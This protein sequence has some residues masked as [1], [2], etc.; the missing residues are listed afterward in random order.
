MPRFAD[1]LQEAEAIA[2]EYQE[3]EVADAIAAEEPRRYGIVRKLGHE[4]E[5]IYDNF[6]RAAYYRLLAKEIK[7]NASSTML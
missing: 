7:H 5:A 2:V 6:L 4:R 3:Y 1:I